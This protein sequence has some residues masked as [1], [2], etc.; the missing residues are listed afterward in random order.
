MITIA[1][2]KELV[3]EGFVTAIE[4]T[5]MRIC[6]SETNMLRYVHSIRGTPRDLAVKEREINYIKI[7]IVTFII[8][9][10][11]NCTIRYDYIQIKKKKKT[12]LQYQKN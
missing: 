4:V 11:G 12:V 1:L 3:G 8:N 5:N 9:V 2:F 10:S 6:C 7:E